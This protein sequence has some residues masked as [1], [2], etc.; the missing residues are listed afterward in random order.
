MDRA[1][2]L[3]AT[4]IDDADRILR[5]AGQRGLPPRA[6]GSKPGD[7][8]DERQ[9]DDGSRNQ[10]R[11]ALPDRSRLGSPH[12]CHLAGGP[13]LGAGGL[14]RR[15]IGAVNGEDPP[16]A[17]YALQLPGASILE[18]KAGSGGEVADGR[19]H[20][21]FAGG[22]RGH[23]PGSDGNGDSADL[24]ADL[25]DLADMHAGANLETEI[26]DTRDDVEGARDGC[27]RRIEDGE[28]PIAGRVH[29]PTPVATERG[30]D[31]AMVKLD[32]F[33]PRL[34][35]EGGGMLG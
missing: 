6:P 4:G 23:D 5:H 12:G 22:C 30:T 31:D 7:H 14:D 16:F 28:E 26:L 18:S 10:A 24:G 32:E 15:L 17:G 20:Q 9:T 19:R 11:S 13:R 1:D 8:N 33:S 27:R 29:L 2:E 35:T 21:D 3:R 25:L 34:V